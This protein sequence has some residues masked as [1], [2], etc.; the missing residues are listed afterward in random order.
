MTT[1]PNYK[2]ELLI[3]HLK[4]HV[5][6]GENSPEFKTAF[7]ELVESGQPAVIPLIELLKAESPVRA[8]VIEILGKIGDK[9]A[10]EFLIARLKDSNT[11]VCRSAIKALAAL[12]D[13]R[14][15]EPL[16]NLLIDS[17]EEAEVRQEA[18]QALGVLG[19]QQTITTLEWI[20]ESDLNNACW[21]SSAKYEITEAIQKIKQRLP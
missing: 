4:K 13:K 18:A 12:D 21:L 3:H 11:Q 16:L 5:F 19:D 15:V 6:E 8:T 10:V 2:I 9:Q 7:N 14:A 20:Q 1:N 17:E